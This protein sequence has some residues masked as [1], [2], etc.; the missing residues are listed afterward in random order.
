MTLFSKIVKSQNICVS[1]NVV[2]LKDRRFEYSASDPGSQSSEA[3]AD[4]DDDPGQEDLLLRKNSLTPLQNQLIEKEKKRL[5]AQ[6]DW[7]LSEARN[8][9]WNIK[10]LAYKDGYAA[11]NQALVKDIAQ[12]I[13]NVDKVMADLQ[14]SLDQFTSQ[15]EKDLLSLALTIA[16]KVLCK[17]VSEDDEAMAELIHHAVE[18]VKDAEWIS[19]EVAESMSGHIKFLS[20]ELRHAVGSSSVDITMK[21]AAPGLCIIKTPHGVLDASISTQLENLKRQFNVS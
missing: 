2:T 7:I 10:N 5:Q 21:D 8:E 14:K 11:G 9:A 6:A 13:Q 20:E 4:Q 1:G 17:R 15:Y 19:V 12:C 18:S 16:S 3:M